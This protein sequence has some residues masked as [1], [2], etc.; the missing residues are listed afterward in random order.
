MASALEPYFVTTIL[1]VLVVFAIYAMRVFTIMR[2]VGVLFVLDSALTLEA[3]LYSDVISIAFLHIITIP[4]FFFLIYL[5]LIHNHRNSFRCFLCGKEIEV[6]TET[7]SIKRTVNRRYAN[8]NVHLEC[9][10][11]GERKAFSERKF[12]RGIPR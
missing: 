10:S 2:L 11:I 5:D 9:L 8:S 12:R 1:F 4:A 3:A 6:G 7:V